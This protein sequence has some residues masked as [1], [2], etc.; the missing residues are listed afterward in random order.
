MNSLTEFNENT[1]ANR[2]F[3]QLAGNAEIGAGRRRFE[4]GRRRVR[5]RLPGGRVELVG[6]L[7]FEE[8]SSLDRQQ[9]LALA[10]RLRNWF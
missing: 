1:G 6:Q 2:R 3:G 10:H 9:I 5:L 7:A 8:E 4:S